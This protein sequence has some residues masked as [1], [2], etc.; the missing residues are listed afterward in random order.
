MGVVTWLVDS[1]GVLLVAVAALALAVVVRRRWLARRGA[2]F[3]LSVNPRRSTTGRGWTL[4]LGLYNDDHL[5]WFRAFSL[6][7]RPRRRFRRGGLRVLA[8]RS[9]Q[10]REAFSLY[11][12]HV[13]L[14]CRTGTEPIQLALSTAS[15]TALLAWLEAG[16]PGEGSGVV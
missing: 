3:E 7:W 2:V 8:K 1:L 11:S 16:P 10:G 9:P 12:G 6:S 4:G 5:E 15:M 14:D 13:I